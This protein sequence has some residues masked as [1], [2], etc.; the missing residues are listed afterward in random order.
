MIPFFQEQASEG[1]ATSL[2]AAL[3]IV[4]AL[5]FESSVRPEYHPIMVRTISER[6]WMLIAD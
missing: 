3:E 2:I 4:T 1:A 5:A 6:D